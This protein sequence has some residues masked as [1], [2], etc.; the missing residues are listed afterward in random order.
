MATVVGL[1]DV[2]IGALIVAE[3]RFVDEIIVPEDRFVGAHVAAV[4]C[5]VVVTPDPFILRSDTLEG[6]MGALLVYED[7]F[8]DTFLVPEDG[9]VGAY[10]T[11]FLDID[12]VT[13]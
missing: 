4:V 7:G 5:D 13:C 11:K 12:V 6:L 10:V 9:L 2:L 3:D 8:V 1:L